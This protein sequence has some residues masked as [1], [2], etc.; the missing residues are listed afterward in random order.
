MG[1]AS[2]FLVSV[3]WNMAYSY[4]IVKSTRVVWWTN[5]NLDSTPF[6]YMYMYV[7]WGEG[8]GA[9][10]LLMVHLAF[11]SCA[12]ITSLHTLISPHTTKHHL[13]QMLLY[14]LQHQL[15]TG[16]ELHHDDHYD[17]PQT[18]ELHCPGK[19]R[20]NKGITDAQKKGEQF[21]SEYEEV[22]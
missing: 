6:V 13:H 9:A 10:I 16:S 22:K 7:L 3:R 19:E 15:P 21:E 18:V 1:V 4:A 17:L 8:G 14:S 2:E 11:C 12:L 20:R 5:Y